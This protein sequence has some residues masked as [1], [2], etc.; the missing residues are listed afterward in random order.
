[1]R[2]QEYGKFKKKITSSGIEPETFRFVAWCLNHYAT[3]SLEHTQNNNFFKL[4]Y[5]KGCYESAP[6]KAHYLTLFRA[7]R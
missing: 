4:N 6:I 2:P 5:G 3:G 7:D 1:M